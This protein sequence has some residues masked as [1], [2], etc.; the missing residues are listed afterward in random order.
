MKNTNT[1]YNNRP[2]IANGV[3]VLDVKIFPQPQFIVLK[4]GVEK[5]ECTD[6]LIK[7]RAI[8]KYD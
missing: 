1:L 8:G 2:C 4:D 5:I 7:P 6:G 3:L